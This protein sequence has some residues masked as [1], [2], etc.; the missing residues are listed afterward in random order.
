[1]AI[2]NV[3]RFMST[4]TV[5]N[6]M[7]HI[8]FNVCKEKEAAYRAQC[9]L[10]FKHKSVIANWGN[11]RPYTVVDIDFKSNPFT[12]KFMTDEGKTYSMS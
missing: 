2:D 7:E 11:K 12:Y 9:L 10:E 5:W 6:R 4:Q 1:M 8:Y 3:F